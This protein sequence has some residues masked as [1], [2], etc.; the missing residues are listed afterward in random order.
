MKVRPSGQEDVYVDYRRQLRI[1]VRSL[2]E[3][4]KRRDFGNAF[5][6]NEKGEIVDLF[7]GV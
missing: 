6:L 3:D 7:Q 4:L 5:A 2:K 1:F